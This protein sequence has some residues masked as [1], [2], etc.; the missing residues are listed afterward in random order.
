MEESAHE[1]IFTG[2]TQFGKRRPKTFHKGFV[3]SNDIF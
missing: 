1:A 2:E 3:A